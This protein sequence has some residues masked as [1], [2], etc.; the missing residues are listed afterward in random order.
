MKMDM[1]KAFL[2]LICLMAGWANGVGAEITHDTSVL[3]VD[4]A[5]FVG[6]GIANFT[7]RIYVTVCNLSNMDFEGYFYLFRKNNTLFDDGQLNVRVAAGATKE[8][9]IDFEAWGAGEFEY[10]VC[11]DSPSQHESRFQDRH[12]DPG[13][14]RERALRQTGQWTNHGEEQ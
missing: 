1:K 6:N 3:S 7:Q 9:G 13:E 14:W 12:D 2:M 11:A 4:S 8:V 10:L 5:T